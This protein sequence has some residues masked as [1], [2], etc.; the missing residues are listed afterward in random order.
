MPQ[1]RILV[2]RFSSLGDVVLTTPLLRAIHRAHPDAQV[3][4]V[5]KTRYA[6][7]FA[8]S[9]YVARV[10]ALAPD[11]TLR[12]FADRVRGPYDARLDLHG[13]LRSL[14]LRALLGGR[15]ATYRKRRWRRRLMVAFKVNALD[16]VPPVAERYFEA[17]TALGVVPDGGPPEVH[18][19]SEAQR[20]AE[21]FGPVGAVVL[22]PG[23]RQATRRWPPDRWRALARS[24]RAAGH[25]PVAV[26]TSS[27]RALLDDDAVVPAYGLPLDVMAAVLRRAAV[28]V[29]HDS[30]AMH[31]AT[32]VGVPVVALFGPTVPA[33]G[34]A[35]YRAPSR[36]IER[37]LACRP[38]SAFGG[39]VCPRGHHRCMIDITP[40]AVADAVAE[41]AA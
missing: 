24:L 38:C 29:A 40:E 41:L 14:A 4:F 15:W 9:P 30:G 28:V 17:A 34:F 35:P 37:T 12:A 11:E 39:P 18:V 21:A 5:T 20:A 32:A 19:S 26:G 3:T 31:L 36:V 7:L 1:S 33:M 27:E 2:V 16:G 13:S 25:V 23:A 8:A 22:A 6:P 10:I